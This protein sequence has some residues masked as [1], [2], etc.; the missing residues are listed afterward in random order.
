MKLQKV[1]G[2]IQPF[3]IASPG[4][5]A[6]ILRAMIQD[7]PYEV[8]SI[9]TQ[10]EPPPKTAPVDEKHIP[11]RPYWGRIERTRLASSLAISERLFRGRFRRT[12]RESL[13]SLK[14][15][16]IHATAHSTDSLEIF[17]VA[18]DLGLPFFL[19]IHDDLAYIVGHH[20][21]TD[22]ILKRLAIM[23]SE[24]DAR[25]VIS[26]EMGEEYSSRYGRRSYEIVTDGL[27]DAAAMPNN[28]S[29]G[30]LR[31]Y[32]MG[33]FHH[34]YAP[35][36]AAFVEATNKFAIGHP[37]LKITITCRCGSLPDIKL[38]DRVELNVLPFASESVVAQDMRSADLLYQP[39]PFDEKHIGL[40]KFSL[41]TKMVSYLGTGIPIL[42]HGPELAAAGRLL[43]RHSAAVC[44]NTLDV[45][46]I[47]KSF[48]T[49]LE[50]YDSV[51]TS[52]LSLARSDFR[53]QDIRERFWST[54]TRA[55]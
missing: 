45:F 42:Y 14:L 46:S 4:G 23:W 22:A 15:A 36:F 54:I 43:Q 25:F 31:I 3:G 9:T 55:L 33:L 48:D 19:S 34:S 29:P 5:G 21:Q 11:S 51:A 26:R 38:P 53:L 37:N 52:A 49:I 44:V 8:L 41:S 47:E 39:L 2:F 18:K 1:I 27:V 20:F 13:S 17:S 16:G 30:Q 28:L 12:I 50:N 24:A 40:T 10:P 35:N 32:F 7:A 6:R